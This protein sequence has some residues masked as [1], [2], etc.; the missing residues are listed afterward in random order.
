MSNLNLTIFILQKVCHRTLKRTNR[1]C[2]KSSRMLTSLNAKPSSFNSYHFYSRIVNKRIEESYRITPTTYAGNKIVWQS[3]LSAD[4]L[5]F[6]LCPYHRLKIP[7][8]HRIR[9]GAK[10]RTEDIMGC[11]HIGGPVP[12]R[13]TYCVFQCLAPIINRCHLCPEE[14]HSEDIKR[15]PLHIFCPHVHL[16]LES[17]HGSNCSSCNTM[18]TCACLSNYTAFPHT[19]R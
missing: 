12:H 17:K 13:L 11:A 8:H 16:A 18:L 14:P 3:P 10:H 5:L 7:D 15:L 19:P 9:M 2:C 4:Y 1:A 6:C